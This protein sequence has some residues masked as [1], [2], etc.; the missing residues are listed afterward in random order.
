MIAMQDSVRRQTSVLVLVALLLVP[1][2]LSGHWHTGSAPHPCSVCAVAHHTP[3]VAPPVAPTF[4]TQ[5]ACV[6]SVPPAPA[7]IARVDRAP[8]TGRAPP[9]PL[10]T[11]V[12]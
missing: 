5:F 6:L 9:S 1:V 2:A 7:R 10:L 8:R 4:I 3:I 11:V 12:A